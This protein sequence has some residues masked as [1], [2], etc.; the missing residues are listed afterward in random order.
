MGLIALIISVA[1]I[2]LLFTD[3]YLSPKKDSPATEFQPLTASGTEASTGIEQMHADVDAAKKVQE[4]LNKQNA[5][6]Q[7]QI[8]GLQ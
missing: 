8:D 1:I 3:M 5:E 4:D 7:R 6:T 2:A